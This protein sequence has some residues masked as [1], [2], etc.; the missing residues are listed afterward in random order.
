MTA[1]IPNLPA[2]NL[3]PGHLYMSEEPVMIS[4]VLGSSISATMFSHEH[5]VGAACHSIL[6]EYGTDALSRN[7]SPESC[8]YVDYAFEI[9]IERFTM[10]GIRPDEIEVRL[11]GGADLFVCEEKRNNKGCIGKKNIEKALNIISMTGLNM[12]TF[13]S[14]GQYGRKIHFY[15]HT[16]K[17]FLSHLETMGKLELFNTTPD[18]YWR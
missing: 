13:N 17:V 11:F 6:P 1:P 14:G 7:Q 5:K 10:Y 12:V 8:I 4:A 18:K 3:Q 15:T 2:V 9:M 16:G